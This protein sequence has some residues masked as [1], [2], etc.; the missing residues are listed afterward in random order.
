MANGS[1]T[2]ETTTTFSFIDGV[3]CVVENDFVEV[4]KVEV[5][6][7]D[8]T[9]R[10]RGRSDDSILCGKAVEVEANGSCCI[11]VIFLY[12]EKCDGIKI[13]I[14]RHESQVQKTKL[15]LRIMIL[16]IVTNFLVGE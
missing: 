14:R 2:P 11:V 15:K 9:E 12:P 8:T 1:R 13:L 7:R 16:D 10:E 3:I 4:R 6:H 5:D